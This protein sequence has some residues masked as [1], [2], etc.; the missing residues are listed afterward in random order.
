MASRRPLDHTICFFCVWIYTSTLHNQWWDMTHRLEN[1]QTTISCHRLTELATRK[2]ASKP[3]FGPMGPQK[4]GKE[5]TKE[6]ENLTRLTTCYSTRTPT[7]RETAGHYASASTPP[8]TT[9]HYTM[10]SDAQTYLIITP[11]VRIVRMNSHI[12]CPP[13][14]HLQVTVTAL[15][16]CPV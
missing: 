16:G 5:N 11:M 1:T 6:S 10:A 9:P 8:H 13:V 12:P 7:T 4:G 2:T 15:P 3:G 14:L